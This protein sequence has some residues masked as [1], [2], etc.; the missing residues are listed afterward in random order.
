MC[1]DPDAMNE[2]CE[3]CRDPDPTTECELCQ[4]S[5][6]EECVLRP[7]HGAFSLLNEVAPELKHSRYCRFC[8]DDKVEPELTRYEETREKAEQV[9][10]F[11]KTQRKEIPLIRRSK[12]TLRI[13]DCTDR[14]ETILRLAFMAAQEGFNALIDTEVSDQK[15]RNHAHQ[16]TLWHGSGEG[17]MIDE[18]KLDRQFKRNQVY[19]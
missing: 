3:T 10:V 13:R 1:Y 9:F 18:A 11:F 2:R 12:E 6:C 5:L 8:F 19:R 14:D 15:V 4:N 16:K 7:P 17:A